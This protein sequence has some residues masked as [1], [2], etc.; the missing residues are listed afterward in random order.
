MK[1]AAGGENCGLE[2]LTFGEQMVGVGCHYGVRRRGDR[3]LGP[4]VPVT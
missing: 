2:L 3:G 4:F 1:A